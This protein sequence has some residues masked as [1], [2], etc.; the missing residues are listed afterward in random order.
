MNNTNPV[1][2]ISA[3]LYIGGTR[4][5]QRAIFRAARKA[6]ESQLPNPPIHPAVKLARKLEKLP[7]LKVAS[8]GRRFARRTSTASHLHRKVDPENTILRRALEASIRGNEAAFG[9]CQAELTARFNHAN[10]ITVA[11]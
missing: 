11:A 8:L 4:Q 5:Q 2:E 1:E 9:Q 10:G 3:A 7:L 6:Q